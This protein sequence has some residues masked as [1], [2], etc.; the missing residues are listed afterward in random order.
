MYEGASFEPQLLQLKSSSFFRRSPGR[1]EASQSGEF[2]LHYEQVKWFGLRDPQAREN[3]MSLP[4]MVRFMI[5]QMGENFSSPLPIIAKCAFM[6]QNSSE[7][8][9]CL[10]QCTTRCERQ[11]SGQQIQSTLIECA[12]TATAAVVEHL[13]DERRPLRA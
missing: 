6:N 9:N 7:R 13:F 4:A 12:G 11:L 2:S 8:Q 10:R 3:R 5:E 1:T